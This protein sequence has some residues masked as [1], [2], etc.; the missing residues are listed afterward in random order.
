LIYSGFTAAAVPAVYPP[1][2]R[3]MTNVG[4]NGIQLIT[5]AIIAIKSAPISVFRLPNF[6]ASPPPVSV[7][8]QA[9][10]GIRVEATVTRASLS[11]PQPRVSETAS[12]VSLK[13]PIW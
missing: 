10:A 12:Y 3:P 8:I 5:A 9:P 2:N 6:V 4:V 7:P 1:R 13:A 11:P